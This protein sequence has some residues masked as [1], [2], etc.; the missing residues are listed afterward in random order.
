[1]LP[2]GGP[3]RRS[4]PLRRPRLLR[5]SAFRPARLLRTRRL[6]SLSSRRVQP[7]LQAPVARSAQ[8]ARPLGAAT[9]PRVPQAQLE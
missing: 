5:P 8:H 6:G 2:R 7:A 3:V 9:G 4:P 1:M